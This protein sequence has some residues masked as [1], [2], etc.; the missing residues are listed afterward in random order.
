MIFPVAGSDDA[1]KWTTSAK[2]GMLERDVDICMT[3]LLAASGVSI[4]VAESK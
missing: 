1:V 3:T 2:C 4:L